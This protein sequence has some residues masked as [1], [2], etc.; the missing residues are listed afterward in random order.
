M[1][2][3]EAKVS[4]Y[5]EDGHLHEYDGWMYE[6]APGLAIANGVYMESMRAAPAV[7]AYSLTHLPTGRTIGCYPDLDTAEAVLQE[8]AN[9]ADWTAIGYPVPKHVASELRPILVGHEVKAWRPIVGD[10]PGGL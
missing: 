7:T 9:L 4:V 2:R 3:R 8:V 1:T 10:L 5:K 6:E